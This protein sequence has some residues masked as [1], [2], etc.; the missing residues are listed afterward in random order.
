MS[1]ATTAIVAGTLVSA[2]GSLV[3]FAAVAQTQTVVPRGEFAEIS[4][5]R[6]EV[7]MLE[8]PAVVQRIAFPILLAVG[9][10]LGKYGKF[11]DAPDPVSEAT[12]GRSSRH[13]G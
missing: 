7:A 6:S 13:A 3:L 9:R 2:L 8:I 11:K 12:V 10:L 4:R 5:Y 1:R